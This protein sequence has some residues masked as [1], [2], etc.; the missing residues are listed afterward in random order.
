L[1]IEP[2]PMR[3]TRTDGN[4]RVP[5]AETPLEFTG[6]RMTSAVE[7]QIEFEHYHRYCLAR[8]LCDGRDVLDVASGEGYGA[9]LL[10]SVSHSV[11]GVE[12]DPGVV[13][14][15]EVSYRAAN[16]RF[17]QGDALALPLSDASVDVVVSFETLEHVADH[18][19]FIGEVR[20]V[21]RPGG[22]F[23]VS[24]P[25]RAV[26]SAHGSDPNPY[27]VLELTD[28][29]FRSLLHAHFSHVAVLAQRPVLGSLLAAAATRKWRTY[30]RRSPD[31]VEAT[32]GLA[33]AHYLLAIATD[34]SLPDIPSS[35]YLDRRRVQDVVTASLR[36]PLAE[37]RMTELARETEAA[38]A[39]QAANHEE[40]AFL[41]GERDRAIAALS[42]ARQ[43]IVR[44]CGE[45]DRATTALSEARE[46]IA[47]LRVER[48]RSI[49]ALSDTRGALAQAR[50]DLDLAREAADRLAAG[51]R[52]E[53]HTL[54][55]RALAVENS[56]F[57]RATGPLRR[58]SNRLPAGVRANMARTARLMWWTVSLQ[59]RSRLRERAA[60]IIEE[61]AA[62]AA[63]VTALSQQADT[64]L[65]SAQNPRPLHETDRPVVMIID[66]RWPEPDRDT[67]SIEA[68][69]L[70]K[71]M[72]LLGFDVIFTAANEYAATGRHREAVA[73]LGARCLGPS[74]SPSVQAFIETYGDM[75]SLYI[76]TRYT[77]GGQYL[78][79]I[80][81]NWPKAKIVFNTIDLHFLREEREARLF[82]DPQRLES[83]AKTRDREEFLIHRSD[84]TIVV[85]AVERTL[86]M[87]AVPGAYVVVLP[88]ARTERS[89]RPGIAERRDIGFIGSFDHM[90][91]V[92]AVRH[93]LADIWPLIRQRLP[94]CRF[95]IVGSRLPDAV[96]QDAPDDVEYLGHMPDI[97]PWFDRLR[98]SVAP[99]RYGAGMKG[100][101]L[102]SLAAGVPCVCTPIA[103]EGMAL[104]AGRD[105][106]VADTPDVFA[107][108]VV[109]VYQ[110]DEL[111]ARLSEV[112][113]SYVA[114]ESSVSVYTKRLHEML[115]SLGLP[116][117]TPP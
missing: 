97:V 108:S 19:R 3:S 56:T 88:L 60:R 82:H 46:E 50:R 69:N 83:A 35:I 32:N 33:R 78:E 110:D 81:Y 24:T 104:T 37:A 90:P 7:G 113:Q 99:L 36:L 102:S 13:A 9:A 95:S 92:D 1:N 61:R 84:A 71:T 34:G 2:D 116:C 25:D 76:L 53:M 4:F 65:V 39:Q 48:D 40:I 85:S 103:V 105:I 96:L 52:R 114:R 26:Y 18:A 49:G 101:V 20:R 29:E 63:R 5:R 14:H 67:G 100:K 72:R 73:A 117:I 94:N 75:V 27:H 58:L 68:V 77:A 41:C 43:E 45:H 21:L 112:G 16:L 8:D 93:F 106:L 12:I 74:D 79:L 51:L 54:T 107:E 86:L 31:I 17:L 30:E 109:S 55:L 10:A 62:E 87:S 89:S 66:D 70:I 59:L 64:L 11:T 38:Q 28:P 22:L 6:E 57:W 91:N 80:R 115:I 15:A 98:V 44:L 111:W 23:V 42:E 47:R